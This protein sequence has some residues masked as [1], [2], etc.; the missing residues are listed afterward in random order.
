MVSNGMTKCVF[1]GTETVLHVNGVPMCL[2][3]DQ[4]REQKREE[5]EGEKKKSVQSQTQSSG[6]KAQVKRLS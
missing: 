6:P 4:Q 5:A 2:K 3:C 1:C